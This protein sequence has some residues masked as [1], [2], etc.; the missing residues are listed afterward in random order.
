MSDEEKESVWIFGYGSL[1][2]RP[3]FSY[4]EKKTGYIE[5]WSRKFYQGSTD[6]RGIPEAPGRVV[7]LLPKENSTCWGIAYKVCPKE[8]A[9]ILSYLDFREKGG[10]SRHL[11]PFQSSSTVEISAL[12][13]VAG[14]DNPNYLG[15]APMIEMAQQIHQAQGP[16][17]SNIEYLL[18]LAEG[19]RQIQAKDEHVFELEQKVRSLK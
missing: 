3:G 6:H 8:Q 7:T 14:I 18:R 19:L 10:F 4:L 5:G 12:V 17:G 1:I 11:V 16:S 2:W 15:P 9:S 13:Y